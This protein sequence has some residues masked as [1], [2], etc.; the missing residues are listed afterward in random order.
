M[1][2]S[3]SRDSLGRPL[4]ATK[5]MVSS[6]SSQG[7]IAISQSLGQDTW[8]PAWFVEEL[9]AT[10]ELAIFWASVIHWRTFKDTSYFLVYQVWKV[11]YWCFV[12]ELEITPHFLLTLMRV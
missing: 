9:A 12:E 1:I 10:G 8:Q 6:N 4:P 3:T 11:A 2:C 7:I 5:V